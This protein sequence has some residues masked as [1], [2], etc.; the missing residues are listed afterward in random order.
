MRL[1]VQSFHKYP[2]MCMGKPIG[3]GVEPSR[4][5]VMHRVGVSISDGTELYLYR[6]VHRAVS[7]WLSIL[8]CESVQKFVRSNLY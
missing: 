6:I 5:I 7:V 8:G 1:I 4:S 3:P 2:E